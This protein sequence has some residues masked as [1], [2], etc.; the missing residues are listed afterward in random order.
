MHRTEDLVLERTYSTAA[1]SSIP[2]PFGDLVHPQ[3]RHPGKIFAAFG[4][5]SDLHARTAAAFVQDFRRLFINPLIG[6]LVGQTRF[7]RIDAAGIGP[8]GNGGLEARA[9]RIPRVLI[10]ADVVAFPLQLLHAFENLGHLAPV[11]RSEG[12]QMECS[13]RTPLSFITRTISSKDSSSRSISFL[14]WTMMIPSCLATALQTSI[15]SSVEA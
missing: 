15:I 14:V 11:C 13:I 4:Y 12:F 9:A 5:R 10:E 1:T 3:A 8:A 2:Q 6:F 7:K